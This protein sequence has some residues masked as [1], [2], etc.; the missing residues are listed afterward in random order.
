MNSVEKINPNLLECPYPLVCFKEI[1]APT[2]AYQD[3]TT[4]I[5]ISSLTELQFYNSINDDELTVNF[6]IPLKKLTVP[7]N[8]ELWAAP[9]ITESETPSIL[10]TNC[11]ATS[12]TL[13]LSKPCC[14]FGFELQ[15]SLFE[16]GVTAKVE[17]YSGEK[18]VGTIQ[19]TIDYLP[20]TALFAAKTC[21]CTPFDKI[22]I[23]IDEPYC[24]FA[25]AQVRYNT[26]CSP[27]CKCKCCFS[28]AI[29]V[30]IEA[31][32]DSV[33]LPLKITKLNC[34]GRLLTFD[35][36]VTAC[37]KSSVVVGVLVC[38]KTSTKV[39]RFK[40][41][42]ACMLESTVPGKPCVEHTFKFCFV[43]E[44]NLCRSV[45]LTIK[46]FSEYACFDFPCRC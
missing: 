44:K 14:T 20:N 24:G 11:G 8:W 35:V 23:S 7:D 46:T 15:P 26:D 18:L 21:C 39:L 17:F 31:C 27:D 13:N 2:K 4:K 3:S 38:D 22:E 19:K 30:T 10:Y 1:E 25:I 41:C 43:F 37:E 12:L 32:K 36:T 45:P 9:P 34:I 5:D 29:P 6:S 42:E 40:V 16:T 28:Y 33:T